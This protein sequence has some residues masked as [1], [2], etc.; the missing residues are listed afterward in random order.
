MTQTPPVHITLI[1]YNRYEDTLEC[2]RSLD[3]LDYP[4]F[5]VMVLDNGSE[6]DSVERLRAA[7]PELDL[8]T[9]TPNCGFTRAQNTAM[10]YVLDRG[11]ELVWMLNN[12]TVVAPDALSKLVEKLRSDE[13]YGA[14]GSVVMDMADRERIQAWG[15][16][17]VSYFMGRAR[18]VSHKVDDATLDYLTGASMLIPRKVLEQLDM[19]DEAFFLYW[20]DAD[21]GTRVRKAGWKLGVAE[22]SRIWHKESATT[23]KRSPSMEYHFSRSMVRFF[24]K[25]YRGSAWPVTVGIGGQWA[26]RALQGDFKRCAAVWKGWREA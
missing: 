10:R 17:R 11:A 8:Q 9:V 3:Q 14:V 22:S 7:R 1:N 21:F 18:H 26:K 19:L 12:D 20:D 13:R 15:G 25:H 2:L 24:K 5:H 4:D 23:Q 16:G 6:N